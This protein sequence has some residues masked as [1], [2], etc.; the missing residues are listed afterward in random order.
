M[1]SPHIYS[2][3]LFNV[4]VYLDA[5]KLTAIETGIAIDAFPLTSPFTKSQILDEDYVPE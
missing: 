2:S 4:D 3:F 1:R 5:R